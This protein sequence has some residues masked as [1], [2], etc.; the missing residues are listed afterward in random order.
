MKG[1][2]NPTPSE[3]GNGTPDQIG[4][5][6]DAMVL[7]LKKQARRRLIG[8][9]AL[10][11]FGV[12][13]LPMM[14]DS[15]P[16]PTAPEIQVHIPDQ[17]GVG[18]AGKIAPGSAVKT[19]PIP[20]SA[21]KAVVAPNKLADGAPSETAATQ[22]VPAN[23]PKSPNLP[24]VP[25]SPGS[26]SPNLGVAA[27]APA[28]AKTALPSGN[29]TSGE[30]AKASQTAGK[31]DQVATDKLIAAKSKP[32]VS[33]T[34]EASKPAAEGTANAPA[35]V[36]TPKTQDEPRALA[37]LTGTESI[38]APWTVQLGAYKEAKN[39]KVLVA[40][41]KEMKLPVTTE[42]FESSLGPRVRVKAGPFSTRAEAEKA[43][44]RIRTI[45][46]NGVLSQ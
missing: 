31:T 2:V 5:D 8:A 18:L 34:A 27:S 4:D 21:P 33:K 16:R 11:L 40:K 45:G 7:Q 37:A 46:V 19:T 36:P 23:A 15:Q 44:A 1:L 25:A 35:S 26:A 32:A 13:T 42:K 29:V 30:S 14:M 9:I 22:T 10:A 12:I 17:D 39:V 3:S 20:A 28:N 24:N 43:Q 41:V 38:S 6:A